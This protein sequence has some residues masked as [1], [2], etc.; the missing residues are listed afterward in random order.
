MTSRRVY[1][2]QAPAP[3]P[4]SPRPASQP[5]QA[6]EVRRR[7][8][9]RYLWHAH[10]DWFPTAGTVESPEA[11]GECQKYEWTYDYATDTLT[12]NPELPKGPR[13]YLHRNFVHN[14]IARSGK[15]P[16]PRQPPRRKE[17]L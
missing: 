16:E 11:H 4:A 17:S 7:R 14:Q 6:P 9:W 3:A 12:C 13:A 15:R 10:L 5:P 8:C 2:P 1:T